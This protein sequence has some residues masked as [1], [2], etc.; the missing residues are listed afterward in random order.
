[1]HN[2][3]NQIVVRNDQVR[4]FNNSQMLYVTMKLHPKHM[5]VVP[6]LFLKIVRRGQINFL[7][8]GESFKNPYDTTYHVRCIVQ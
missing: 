7:S 5:D 3:L 4:Q 1:M 2:T 6:F 8:E